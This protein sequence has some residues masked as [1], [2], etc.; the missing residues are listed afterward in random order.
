MRVVDGFIERIDVSAIGAPVR[1]RVGAVVAPLLFRRHLMQAD[2]ERWLLI[3]GETPGLVLNA[4]FTAGKEIGGSVL[5]LTGRYRPVSPALYTANPMPPPFP[6]M[7]R[8]TSVP[9]T[10]P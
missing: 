4:I 3:A 7:P 2:L 1:E 10:P 9:P 6:P 5:V 8:L